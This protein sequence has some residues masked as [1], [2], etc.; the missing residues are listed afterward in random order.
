MT[1]AYAVYVLEPIQH[2]SQSVS[3]ESF[4][5][6]MSDSTYSW[7]LFQSKFFESFKEQVSFLCI[8]TLYYIYI[9]DSKRNRLTFIEL[10]YWFIFCSSYT[11]R[12]IILY[13][14]TFISYSNNTVYMSIFILVISSLISVISLI[15]YQLLKNNVF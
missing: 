4:K 3:Y 15:Y 2:T 12:Q 1:W 6:I 14:F 7:I 9:Y 10:N 11:Y 13:T 8:Y 5:V